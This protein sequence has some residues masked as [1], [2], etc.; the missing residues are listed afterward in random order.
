MHILLKLLWILLSF[1]QAVSFLK[2]AKDHVLAGLM[3]LL[4]VANHCFP[5]RLSHATINWTLCLTK[6]QMGFCS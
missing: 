2:A 6:E 5:F 3:M 4:L 1:W